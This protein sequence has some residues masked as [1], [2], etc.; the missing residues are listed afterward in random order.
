[1][2]DFVDGTKVNEEKKTLNEWYDIFMGQIKV[3]CLQIYK[4]WIKTNYII[5]Y[6]YILKN[7]NNNNN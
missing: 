3:N 2:Y 1:M 7:N 6:T 5:Q 4:F